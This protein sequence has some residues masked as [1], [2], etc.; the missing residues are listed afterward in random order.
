M[1]RPPLW[2]LPV[3]AILGFAITCAKVVLGS[4]GAVS[5]ISVNRLND[6]SQTGSHYPWE[7]SS[8]TVGSDFVTSWGDM[9]SSGLGNPAV[10]ASYTG[11]WNGSSWSTPTVHT[12]GSGSTADLFL[13]TN[14]QGKHVLVGVGNESGVNLQQL[15]FKISTDSTGSSWNSPWTSS[16]SS[17]SSVTFD[18]PSVAVSSDGNTVAIGYNSNN[19]GGTI[20]GSASIFSTDGGQTFA[21]PCSGQPC[22][23]TTSS[24]LA[25]GRIVAVGGTFH[26]FVADMSNLS[27]VHLKRYQW[28][29]SAWFLAE[30]SSFS[31]TAPNLSFP[32]SQPTFCNSANTK[33]GY[34]DYAPLIDAQATSS[35]WVVLAPAA[36]ADNADIN[37]FVLCAGNLSSGCTSVNYASDLFLGGVTTSTN[38]DIWVSMLTYSGSQGTLNYTLPLEQIASYCSSNCALSSSWI[39]GL[40]NTPQNSDIDPTQ[41]AYF[42]GDLVRCPTYNFAT[43]NCFAAGDYARLA[44]NSSTVTTLPF[45]TASSGPALFQTFVQDPQTGLRP[46]QGLSFTRIVPGADLT[47]K[48]ALTAAQMAWRTP[49]SHIRLILR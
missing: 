47:Y 21:G 18:Y 32:S 36:R 24:T 17:L 9:P 16:N 6:S 22:S 33:C 49:S 13:A 44:M 31:Y 29:G 41:W 28:N 12:I 15:F 25:A 37:N 20:T 1:T 4:G 45:V 19:G 40:P 43:Q 42:Q 39:S 34:I 35:G 38:G 14:N 11:A 27:A 48:G 26:F 30:T 5:V 7:P 46:V 3:L 23:I 8:S 10:T 2:G